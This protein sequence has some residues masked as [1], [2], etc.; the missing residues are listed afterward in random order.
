MSAQLPCIFKQ[1]SHLV[2]EGFSSQAAVLQQYQPATK[3]SEQQV[4]LLY[5]YFSVLD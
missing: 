1:R 3:V 4:T 5:S 2:V